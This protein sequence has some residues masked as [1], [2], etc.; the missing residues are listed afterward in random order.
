MKFVRQKYYN[1]TKL[2]TNESLHTL[3][4]L[5]WRHART[6]VGVTVNV[7]TNV[8]VELFHI[9]F[10][11]TRFVMCTYSGSIAFF[12]KPRAMLAIC[13]GTQT[14]TKHQT[15]KTLLVYITEREAPAEPT[16]MPAYRDMGR[17]HSSAGF[18]TSG[19]VRWCI[20][21]S[22]ERCSKK[23]TSTSRLRFFDLADDAWW[24]C[25]HIWTHH[26]CSMEVKVF[27]VQ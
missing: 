24:R 17:S 3:L 10:C 21:A 7:C 18:A 14:R 20:C 9:F 27:M 2:P 12:R 23:P 22:E 8:F 11:F 1:N 26:Q 13:T 25:A 5:R 16:A 4:E 6:S 15:K 19:F